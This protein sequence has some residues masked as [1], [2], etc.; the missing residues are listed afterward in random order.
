MPDS[1]IPSDAELCVERTWSFSTRN[2]YRAPPCLDIMAELQ[3]FTGFSDAHNGLIETALHEAVLNAVIHGNLEMGSASAEF[4]D[5]TLSSFEAFY[6][7]V[8]QKLQSAN[9]A[10]RQVEIAARVSN[11]TL[12]LSV[13]D[14]GKGFET[15]TSPS[16]A[17]TSG[18]GML[19]IGSVADQCSHDLGGRRITMVFNP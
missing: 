8:D 19:I 10:E 7:A 1:P 13:T 11:G 6:Q 16:V 5:G 9:L 3:A 18:R 15:S 12:T 14:E 17:R 4:G 2:A